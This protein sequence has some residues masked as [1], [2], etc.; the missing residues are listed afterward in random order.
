MSTEGAD[1]GYI[2]NWLSSDCDA[3]QSSLNDGWAF[4]THHWSSS[5]AR[6][7]EPWSCEEDGVH[8]EELEDTDL[9]LERQRTRASNMSGTIYEAP[10]AKGTEPLCST[11]SVDR[12]EASCKLPMALLHEMQN[13]RSHLQIA[14]QR[15]VDS[16]KHSLASIQHLSN[17]LVQLAQHPSADRSMVDILRN[18]CLEDSTDLSERFGDV[19]KAQ[20]VFESSLKKLAEYEDRMGTGCTCTRGSNAAHATYD[21]DGMSEVS[22][23]SSKAPPVLE[24]YFELAGEEYVV[25]ER[26]TELD[27]EHQ[28]ALT[29]YRKNRS[30][31]GHQAQESPSNAEDLYRQRRRELVEARGIARGQ[32]QVQRDICL[33]QGINPEHHRYRRM[34]APGGKR[35]SGRD[36]L[37]DLQTSGSKLAHDNVTAWLQYSE[38]G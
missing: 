4:V 9:C 19:L 16:R 2:S 17:A 3:S 35:L 18:Q 11:K 34:T 1:S 13:A 28:E 5:G 25:D 15:D 21:R 31:C 27:V 20:E 38:G 36:I 26:L 14:L 6:S 7:A 29:K 30:G 8:E 10:M 23:T 24:R 33:S 37:Q 22:Q 12:L 32:L